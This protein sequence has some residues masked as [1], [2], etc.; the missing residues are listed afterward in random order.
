[1]YKGNDWSELVST[2]S[3]EKRCHKCIGGKSGT[4]L[5]VD[6]GKLAQTLVVSA[7]VIHDW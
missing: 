5:N 4:P 3:R 1:M 2:L 7:Q 6:V